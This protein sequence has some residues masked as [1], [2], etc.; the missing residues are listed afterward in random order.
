VSPRTRLVHLLKQNSEGLRCWAENS[1]PPLIRTLLVTS[2]DGNFD[3]ERFRKRDYPHR[4]FGVLRMMEPSFVAE[5]PQQTKNSCHSCLVSQKY[6]GGNLDPERPRKTG[7]CHLALIVLRTTGPFSVV[8]LQISRLG[9]CA[10]YQ[11]LII[12]LEGAV[13]HPPRHRHY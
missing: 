8:E 2:N 6:L 4:M 1:V 3:L 7:C 10:W 5:S 9:S 11:F 13:L 12:D